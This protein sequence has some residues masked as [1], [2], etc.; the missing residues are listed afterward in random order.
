MTEIL[1]GALRDKRGERIWFPKDGKPYFDR[2]LQRTFNTPREKKEYMDK[3]NLVMDGSQT[4]I[5]MESGD[6][7]DKLFRKQVR[8]ED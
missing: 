2:S 3:N 1:I 8:M 6:A 7:R 5:K 4:K